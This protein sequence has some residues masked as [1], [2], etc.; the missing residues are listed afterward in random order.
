MYDRN[1]AQEL[2]IFSAYSVRNLFD[3]DTPIKILRRFDEVISKAFEEM[4]ELA[5][6]IRSVGTANNMVEACNEELSKRGYICEPII[7]KTNMRYLT[8]FCYFPLLDNE[9][10]YK[11]LCPF[12]GIYLNSDHVKNL[13]EYE[14]KL[15]KRQNRG[16][17]S[18]GVPDIGYS[19]AHEVGHALDR[20][21][22][23]SESDE[24]QAIYYAYPL[25]IS[26]Y[27][28]FSCKEFFAEAYAEYSTGENP[29]EEALKVKK[30]VEAAVERERAKNNSDNLPH[31]Q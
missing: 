17:W 4:P 1:R 29:R 9:Y 5:Y 30:I 25:A 27:G 31:K 7:E 12:A 14:D 13:N 28:A 22:N 24:L 2:K 11:E 15:I 20:W 18:K 6:Y 21:L 26:T 16:W 3:T 23:I 8:N 10:A 19:V